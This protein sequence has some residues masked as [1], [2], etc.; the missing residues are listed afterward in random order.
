MTI[1]FLDLQAVN[2]QYEDELNAA[3]RQVI[4]SGWY[5]HGLATAQFEHD[6]A[7]YIGTNFCIGVANGLDALTLIY[8]AYIELGVMQPDDEVIVPA[9]TFIAS[10]LAITENGLKPV[11]VEPSLQTLEMDDQLIEQAITPRTK[12]I[13]LVHLYGR[14]AY[15]EH[16]ASLC[17]RYNLKLV[18]DN[19]QA[20]G[21]SATCC[22][23]ANSQ[24]STLNSQLK[25]LVANPQLSTLNS[26]LKKTGSLGHAAGH[27]FYPG[28]NLGALGDGGAVTTDDPELAETVRQLANYGSS[29]KCIFKRKGRNSRLD[30]LQAAFL[31]VKLGHL[32]DDNRRRQRIASYY[33][34][35]IS[36]PLISLPA[37]MADT[38]NV[39]HLFPI[40]SPL[41]DQL[42][43]HLAD[44]GIATLI[45]YPIPPH[46]QECYSQWSH[47][48]LPVTERIHQ[49]ELSLPISPVLSDEEAK[50]V[51]EAVNSF[52]PHP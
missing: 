41:R 35:H 11:L 5:L 27:S 48:S 29:Q 12:S 23:V 21:C 8:R 25:N 13:L 2:R 4:S 1:P 46:Q 47:L 50:S 20:H 45:H 18:E 33:Y 31:S 19:A 26:Q 22:A 28:K 52:T 40:F 6:Y 42:Q 15:T 17:R 49:T 9:N 36:H 14:C 7:R 10:I 38:G 16:I 3:A 32:D 44:Y 30:E 39:Y 37:R 51:V 34:D 43:Q 24:P